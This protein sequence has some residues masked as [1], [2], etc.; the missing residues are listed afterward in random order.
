MNTT[1]EQKVDAILR[2]LT[3]EDATT[4]TA[5]KN[6]LLELKNQ[7]TVSAPTPITVESAVAELLLEIGI[8]DKA[9]GY[10]ALVAAISCVVKDCDTLSSF[11]KIIYPYAAQACNCA[12]SQVE[13]RMRNAI[14]YAWLNCDPEPMNR[15]FG[16][17]I[18][19]NKGKP[20]NSEF[21]AR[22]AYV[23][24]QRMGMEVL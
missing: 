11:T 16:N 2:Y 15:L 3:A 19:A 24:R 5:A 9:S 6:H 17:T 7:P 12:P 4:A 14:E 23:V 22:C 10:R 8:R 1:Y 20:T 13:K 21:I 18:N